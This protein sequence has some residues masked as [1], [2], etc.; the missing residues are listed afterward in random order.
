MSEEEVFQNAVI[1]PVIKML[2]DLLLAYFKHYLVTKK[3][4]FSRLPEREQT[5]FIENAFNKDTAF[6]HESRGMVIGHLSPEE[7]LCYSTMQH[8]INRRI[9]TI[10][11]ER[12]NSN[13]ESLV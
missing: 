4:D 10:L 1:R 9:N 6:R 13:R 7:Y 11:K 3:I 2:H 5:G 12:I 8:E